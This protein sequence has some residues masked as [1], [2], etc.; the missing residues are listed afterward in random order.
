MRPAPAPPYPSRLI[1]RH[2]L[3][4]ET[5]ELRLERP[6]G[7]SFR[8]G[9]RVQIVD[10]AAERDYS[11]VCG[12][13]SAELAVC[14]RR[15]PGGLLSSRLAEMPIGNRLRIAGPYGYFCYEPAD[16]PVIFVA[17]GTG[18]APFRSMAADSVTGFTLLHGVRDPEECYYASELRKTAYRYI[19]CISGGS[20]AGQGGFAG[21]VTDYSRLHLSSGRYEFYLSGRR[22]M[23][24]DMTALIDERFPDSRV[25]T[26]IFF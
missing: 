23:I 9:Q 19:P 22:E 4:P 7:F 6:D 17:T 16:D 1:G 14:I 20:A 10:E 18:I 3:S 2:W 13:R 25:Y 12:P 24:R 8:A 21:R 5:F 15:I 26:E 11:L